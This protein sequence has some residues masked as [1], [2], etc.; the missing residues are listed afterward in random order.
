MVLRI[1]RSSRLANVD[2]RALLCSSRRAGR[3]NATRSC[4]TTN[5]NVLLTPRSGP[6]AEREHLWL[7]GAPVRRR[8]SSALPSHP[9]GAASCEPV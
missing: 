2:L 9:L 5:R 7:V 4:D 3:H 8:R 6:D 1:S